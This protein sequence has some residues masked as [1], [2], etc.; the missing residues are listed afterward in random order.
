MH[1]GCKTFYICQDSTTVLPAVGPRNKKF[2]GSRLHPRALIFL[3]FLRIPYME[4]I[5]SRTEFQL[6]ETIFENQRGYAFAF[7]QRQTVFGHIIRR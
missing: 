6:H 4:L 3:S 5:F 2:E 7:L 1:D